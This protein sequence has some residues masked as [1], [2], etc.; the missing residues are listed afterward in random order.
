MDLTVMWCSHYGGVNTHVVSQKPQHKFVGSESG[1]VLVK[2]LSLSAYNKPLPT[3]ILAVVIKHIRTGPMV[4]ESTGGITYRPH[5]KVGCRLVFI[6]GA[7]YDKA[8]CL[9]LGS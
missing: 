1:A 7:A 4:V 3:Q 5:S 2:L 6:N 9:L 8:S